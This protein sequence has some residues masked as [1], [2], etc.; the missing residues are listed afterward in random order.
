MGDMHPVS[1]GGFAAA[2]GVYARSR[3]TYA[4]G[5]I[6]L[7]KSSIP[8]GEVLDVAAGT[9]I[10][11]GQLVRAGCNVMAAEPV[12]EMNAQ[13]RRSLPEVPSVAAV[14]ESLPFVSGHFAGLTVAQAFHWFDAGAA[15]KECARVLREDGV[16]ALLFNVR[17]E[18]VP[19]VARLTELMEEHSGGRPYTDR[20]ERSWEEVVADSGLFGTPIVERFANPVGSSP[21]ALL[22]RVRS[23]SFVAVMEPDAREVLLGEVSEL[24]RNT[25]ELAGRET[26]EYPH[27]TE[28]Y[29][30]ARQTIRQETS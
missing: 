19:W 11:A 7:L 4:R 30:W 29:L 20:R 26:F 6:G 24:M 10:L 8:D 17:D 15:L 9:G 2:A 14:A 22:D 5:A 12:Q 16:L 3:P 28:S 13:M 21:R 18:S 1:A 27:I 23:T 25:P